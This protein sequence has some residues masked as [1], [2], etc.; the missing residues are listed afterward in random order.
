MDFKKEVVPEV[1]PVF[2]LKI[3]Y[4][5]PKIFIPKVRNE[6]GKMVPTIAPGKYW[7][8]KYSFRDPASGKLKE[9]REKK[10]IN[11]INSVALR[12]R[13]VKTLYKAVLKYLQ[14]GYSP[15]KMTNT[16]V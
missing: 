2:N 6:A 12:T 5:D 8:V 4:T 10:G 14:L 3:M 16:E 13:A 1:V 9:F 15:F 11:T 7:Y